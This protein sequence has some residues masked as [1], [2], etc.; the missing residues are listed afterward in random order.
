[1]M[2]SLLAIAV[3]V[4]LSMSRAACTIRSLYSSGMPRISHITAIGRCS[5]NWPTRSALPFSQNSLT[6]CWVAR[7]MWRRMPAVVD[8]RH[9]AGDRAAQPQVLVA[10][11][12]GADGLPGDER[13]ERVVGPDRA[14]LDGGPQ[15]GCRG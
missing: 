12:V 4:P 15:R 13:R 1:M 14:V 5:A 7:L 11:G 3:S 2:Y 9:G 6:R 8:G 10:L